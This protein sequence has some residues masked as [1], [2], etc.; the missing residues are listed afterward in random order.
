MPRDASGTYTLPSGN[1]VVGGTII[2]STWANPTM[3]DIALALTDSLSRTGNGGLLTE[4]KLANGS[5][6]APSLTFTTDPTTGRY[7]AASG[8]MRD[9][10]NASDLVKY[11][12]TGVRT[13]KHDFW[14]VPAGSFTAEQDRGYMTQPN[15]TVT[16]PASPDT[17]RYVVLGDASRAWS[18]VAPVTVA[19]NGNLI[20]G[21]ASVVLDAPGLHTILVYTGTEW[22][23]ITN[24]QYRTGGAAGRS[25]I[26]NSAFVAA[27][28]GASNID[29]LWHDDTLNTWHFVSDST[30]KANGN[31]TVRAGIFNE[32]G[33]ALSSKYLGIN[34]KA[35]DSNL[36]DGIDSATYRDASSAFTTGEVPIARLP[37]ATDAEAEGTS[38]SVLLTPG[39]LTAVSPRLF[40]L[41]GRQTFQGGITLQWGSVFVGNVVDGGAGQ[42]VNVTFPTAFSSFYQA[43]ATPQDTTANSRTHWRLITSS[44]TGCSFNIQEASSGTQNITLAWFAIG[45]V[46]P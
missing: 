11:A 2:A 22:R 26:S 21:A 7:L 16:L 36:L 19:G 20:D 9:V 25:Y 5:G 32:G 28:D 13:F 18:E 29:H 43:Y 34:A 44:T 3:D 10:V 39:N 33:T 35:A 38:D 24:A 41:N 12:S 45:R 14:E 37:N 1:P 31:S 42:T 40:S 46:N 15:V 30:Y 27:S 4:L 8:D 23:M 6:V 17:G